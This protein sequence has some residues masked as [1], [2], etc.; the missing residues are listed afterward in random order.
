MLLLALFLGVWKYRQIAASPE[1]RA[2]PT[3]TSPTAALLYMLLIATFVQ[4]SG[5]GGASIW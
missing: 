5:G 2:D 3:W 4:L 1:A